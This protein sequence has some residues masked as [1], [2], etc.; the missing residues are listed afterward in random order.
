MP[1]NVIEKVYPQTNLENETGE[2]LA[3]R[4]KLRVAELELMQQHELVAELRRRLPQ[5]APLENYPFQEGP[6]DLQAG[7]TPVRTVRLAEL[8]TGPGR[9]LVLYH[10]MYGK[11]QTK[12]CPMCTSFVD[13]I[14]GV[15]AHLEQNV[16][17]AV[18]MAADVPAIRA[19]ARTRNWDRLRLLSAGESTFKYDLKSED[20]EGN[21]DS[22][23]SVLTLDPKGT[24]RHFYSAHPRLSAEAKERG[25][26]LLNPIWNFLD[27]TPAGRGNF[28]A[29]LHYP[30]NP[31]VG[32]G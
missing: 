26:D 24:P 27:L 5:G 15:A 10:M 2:Y 8:F 14:N 1:S 9:A 3:A 21:Q 29:R 17:L 7:D 4:E 6:Q 19:H 23:I 12:P 31:R 25:L 16:D 13:C 22:T 30:V 20:R 11:K 32:R 28:Y 18:V